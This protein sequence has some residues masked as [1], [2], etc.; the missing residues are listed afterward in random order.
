[1]NAA[2]WKEF[3]AALPAEVPRQLL[4]EAN[5]G[6]K[7]CPIC[8]EKRFDLRGPLILEIYSINSAKRLCR[9]QVCGDCREK[10]S[11][12]RNNFKCPVC[13]ADWTAMFWGLVV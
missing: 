11:Q 1:M 7:E 10:M 9:H 2:W 4:D 6:E 12:D 13:R 5:S 8:L 3:K